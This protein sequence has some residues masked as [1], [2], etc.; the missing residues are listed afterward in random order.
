MRSRL[1][2]ETTKITALFASWGSTDR[3]ENEGGSTRSPETP[4]SDDLELE[5]DQYGIVPMQLTVFN[6]GGYY[7]NARDAIAAAKRL[8][9]ST[10]TSTRRS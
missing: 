10:Q 1:P 9:K 3:W 6:W 2:H 7:S 8:A 4:S 5:L